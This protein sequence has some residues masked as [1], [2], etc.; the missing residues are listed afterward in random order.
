MPSVEV[1][2]PWLSGCSHRERAFAWLRERLPYP[3]R[4]GEGGEP[5]IKAHAVYPATLESNADILIVHDADVW[6]DGLEEAVGAVEQGRTWAIPHKFVVRLSGRGTSDYLD[7]APLEACDL[8]QNPYRGAMGGGIV[9]ARRETLL[10]VPL[11]PRFVGWGQ[12]DLAWGLALDSLGKRWRG[13]APLVHLWHP[14]QERMERKWGSIEGRRLFERYSK[15]A[16]TNTM[17]PLLEEAHLALRA[18]QSD[19]L[20]RD[21]ARIG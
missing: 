2:V 6:T 1:I 17:R 15:A 19:V 10:D 4:I 18:H 11:D 12:E 21:P 3:V 7:G 16:Q 9:V 14:A 20:D 13:K 8:E 5:W